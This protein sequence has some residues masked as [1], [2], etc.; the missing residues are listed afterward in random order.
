[1][2]GSGP[3]LSSFEPTGDFSG[4]KEGDVLLV[5]YACWNTEPALTEERDGAQ[6][7]NGRVW[8]DSEGAWRL[9]VLVGRWD[10]DSEDRWVLAGDGRTFRDLVVLGGCK[11]ALA[12]QA[13]GETGLAS[14]ANQRVS[15]LADHAV[16]VGQ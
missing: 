12:G 1:M 9:V 5:L 14:R 10:C 8:K 15:I 11:G 6:L 13:R 16:T 2:L 4:T 3:A 7:D